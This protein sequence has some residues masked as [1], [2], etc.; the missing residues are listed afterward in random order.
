[1]TV[2]LVPNFTGPG[3]PRGVLQVGSTL[4]V[5][6]IETSSGGTWTEAAIYKTT[7]PFGSGDLTYLATWTIGAT[8][9]IFFGVSLNAYNGKFAVVM[10]PFTAS[11]IV[12]VREFNT[13]TDSYEG[14]ENLFTGSS[15]DSASQSFPYA[16]YRPDG[17]LVVYTADDAERVMGTWYGRTCWHRRESSVWT[18][19]V[20]APSGQAGSQTNYFCQGGIVRCTSAGDWWVGCYGGGN[21]GFFIKNDNTLTTPTTTGPL[22]AQAAVL[23]NGTSEEGFHL[24]EVFSTPP[25]T[26]KWR[27]ERFTL[28]GT[29]W[30]AQGTVDL[31]SGGSDL[32]VSRL[33]CTDYGSASAKMH[34][35]YDHNQTDGILY[36][37]ERTTGDTWASEA[38]EVDTAYTTPAS[39]F[40]GL[41]PLIWSDATN[42]QV[43]FFAMRDGGNWRFE[44][45]TLVAPAGGG[46]LP[47]RAFL[48]RNT[49]LVR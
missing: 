23:N 11:G 14:I 17:D 10:M 20:A 7:A 39:P 5:M 42:G 16:V 48:P 21:N 9:G 26:W 4:Y 13:S 31:H 45:V 35:V 18:K 37:R 32:G 6:N 46:M 47:P 27:V 44:P 49:Y 1:M 43:L 25:D 12:Q 24:F 29:T 38:T 33:V 40:H 30:T 36:S 2:R 3:S 34:A 15:L 41:F 19:Q 28:S 22:P 8:S